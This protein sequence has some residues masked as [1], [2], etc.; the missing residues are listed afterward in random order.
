MKI[1][2]PRGLFYYYYNQLWTVFF[3]EIDIDI[4]VSPRTNK[5]IIALGRQYSSDEMCLSIKN[6]IGHAVYLKDKCDYLLIPRIDN[7]GTFNQTCTNFLAIYDYLNNILGTKI[8][9]YNINLNN[10]ETEKKG[11]ISVARKLG[12]PRKKAILAYEIARI[13]NNIYQKRINQDNYHKLD[14]QRFKVL[15][16]SHA[17]NTY[18][19]F[20]GVPIVKMLEKQQVEVLYSD[21][22]NILKDRNLSLAP[23]LYWKYSK[24]ML[25]AIEVCNNSIDGIIF[26][27]TF[28]CGLDSLAN[29]LVMRNIK[30]PYLNLVID[31]LDSMTGLETRIESFI[32]ILNQRVN[33]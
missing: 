23:N 11:L 1:G 25:R 16:V 14:S 24:D 6:Y 19:E 17:Y 29:E 18:D 9:N 8:I 27:S 10:D 33:S 32:D 31:D 12:I 5:E 21:R 30:I 28:P 13:K 22:F 4:V 20:I 7:Y 3:K 15:L 2:I 26:L